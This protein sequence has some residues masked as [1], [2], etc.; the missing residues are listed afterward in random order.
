MPVCTPNVRHKTVIAPRKTLD[1]TSAHTKKAGTSPVA[2]LEFQP[3][4]PDVG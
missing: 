2:R 4:Q 1:A 3:P